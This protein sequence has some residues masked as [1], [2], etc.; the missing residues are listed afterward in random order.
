M[1]T[2]FSIVFL[3]AIVLVATLP[4]LKNPEDEE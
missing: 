3:V 4:L 2:F 1:T